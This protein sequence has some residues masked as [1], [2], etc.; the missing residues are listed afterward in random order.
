MHYSE[1]I[2]Y[3]SLLFAMYNFHWDAFLVHHS[4]NHCIG[5]VLFSG[6]H[7][8]VIL[9]IFGKRIDA[10]PVRTARDTDS[11]V[12]DHDSV[13]DWFLGHVSAVVG[14]VTVVLHQYVHWVV[15]GIDTRHL[16]V[17]TSGAAGIHGKLGPFVDGYSVL[18]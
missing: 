2:V 17:S 11:A 4:K 12:T 10:Y 8:I 14:S 15:F 5:I 13:L 1:N 3:H 6:F 18:L 16:Q 9:S 7:L